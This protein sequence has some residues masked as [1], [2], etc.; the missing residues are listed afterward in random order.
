MYNNDI[1]KEK[2]LI[3]ITIKNNSATVNKKF[4]YTNTILISF[5]FS[6]TNTSKNL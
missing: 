4:V 3:L 5:F 2:E 1:E 6:I